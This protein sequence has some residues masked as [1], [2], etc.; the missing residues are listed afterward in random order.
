MVFR[1]VVVEKLHPKINETRPLIVVVRSGVRRGANKLL[2]WIPSWISPTT[3]TLVRGACLGPVIYSRD[4]PS[5][6]FAITLF[7]ALCDI[8]DGE[9]A[10]F[11]N[12][13]TTLGKWLDPFMDKVFNIGTIYFACRHCPYAFRHVILALEIALTVIRPIEKYYDADVSSGD[14][15]K[16]KTWAHSIGI[17][18]VFMNIWWGLHALAFAIGI[19]LA[20]ASLRHHVRGTLQARRLKLA[21]A[22]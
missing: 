6:A 1:A 22:S 10:R 7:S 14:A 20:S 15:G 19:V 5:V 3:I 18:L 9:L 12:K 4:I 8:T 11:R 16:A 13:V 17:L 2:S 21:R